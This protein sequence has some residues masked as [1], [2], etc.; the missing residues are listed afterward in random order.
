M[1]RCWRPRIASV[2]QCW[3]AVGAVAILLGM[4]TTAQALIT[5]TGDPADGLNMAEAAVFTVDPFDASIPKQSNRG[6]TED[7]RLRQTFKN[8]TEINV[9]EIIVTFDVTGGAEEGLGIRIYEVADVLASTWQPLGAPI[10]EIAYQQTLPANDM[11][12]SFELTAG[13]V[14]NL[15]PRGGPGDPAGYGIEISTPFAEPSDGNPGVLWFANND[16]VSPEVDYYAGGRYYTEFGTAS[17]SWRDVGVALLASDE[18]P[19]DPGDVNCDTN[20]DLTDLSIIASHFRQNGIREEGDLSGNG[21]VDF[22]DFDEWKQ[23][24]PGAFPGG[25][26]IADILAGV[27]E[28]ASGL[29]FCIGGSAL[30]LVCGRGRKH[31]SAIPNA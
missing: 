29:L 25:S 16:T 11:Y 15:P 18:V 13:D 1:F 22:D 5:V 23:N 28:P 10:K 31:P 12:M 26:S 3:P 6:I 30:A 8:P 27:P 4:S 21:F 9:G 7:R 14:F 2:V 20:V 24:Y 17:D 19:C